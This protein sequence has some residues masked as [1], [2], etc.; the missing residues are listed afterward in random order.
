MIVSLAR[1]GAVRLDSPENFR[2]FH[3]SSAIGRDRRVDAAAALAAAGMMLDGDHAWVPL[4]WLEQQGRSF[5]DAWRTDFDGMIAYARKMGWVDDG[6]GTVRAH[7]E[8]PD[9]V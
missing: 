2:G 6:A 7:V 9:D 1:D 4:A 5:G 3:V 8:W